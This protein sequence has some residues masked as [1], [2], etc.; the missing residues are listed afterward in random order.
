MPGRS[1]VL[2]FLRPHRLRPPGSSVHGKN[3]WFS[4]QEHWAGLPFPPR[5]HLPHPGIRPLLLHRLADSLPPSH[6]GSPLTSALSQDKYVVRRK[7]NGGP[8][9]GGQWCLPPTPGGPRP[10]SA[11]EHVPRSWG[12]HCHRQPPLRLLRGLVTQVPLGPYLTVWLILL[13][14]EKGL[15]PGLP[16]GHADK[17]KEHEKRWHL[18]DGL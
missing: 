5:G 8:S 6:L 11:L 4:R 10:C 18:P 3:P 2:R 14:R 9:D 15:Q 16:G 1:V 7:G 12:R 13:A 17:V